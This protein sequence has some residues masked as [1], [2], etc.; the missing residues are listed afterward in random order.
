MI[1]FTLTIWVC[2][3]L[4]QNLCMAPVQSPTL[5]DSWYECSRAAHQE[6]IKIYSRLGYK[7]GA[8][9]GGIHTPPLKKEHTHI[10]KVNLII[11]K[12]LKKSYIIVQMKGTHDRYN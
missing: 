6:S 10:V 2:S 5:Y 7:I 3:F 11:D 12:V 4:G 1:K 8:C 9:T